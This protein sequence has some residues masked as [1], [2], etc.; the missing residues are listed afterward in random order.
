MER[1]FPYGVTEQL[2]ARGHDMTVM[3][4]DLDFGRGQII[5]RDEQGVLAGGTEPRADGGIA[6][7]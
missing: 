7:Y 5:L 4:N 1:A 6:I 3:P 2:L